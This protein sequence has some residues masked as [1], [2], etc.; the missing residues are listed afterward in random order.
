[1]TDKIFEQILLGINAQSHIRNI[2]YI[3]GNIL[4]PSSA[5][6]ITE[7]CARE[8]PKNPLQELNFSSI[9]IETPESSKDMPLLIQITQ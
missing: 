4:G 9:Q 5:A 3:N 1:M 8:G 2:H 7:I 6:I